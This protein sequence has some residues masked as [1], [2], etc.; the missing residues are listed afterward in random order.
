ME[1]DRN[2]CPIMR[3]VSQIGDKWILG[4]LRE[5]FLG[6]T[7]FDEFQQNL[8]ISKSVLSTKLNKMLEQNLLEK[9]AYQ[10][11]N[12]RKRFEYVLSRKGKDL[13]KVMTALLDWGNE[14]LIEKG[15]PMVNI[16]DLEDKKKIKLTV[17]NHKGEAIRWRDSEMKVL[18]K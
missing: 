13:F 7:K 14:Y 10:K 9:V 2:I 18:K 8:S 5:C 6:S 3:S 11:D 1:I 17:T 15:E 12:E 4:I 16:V